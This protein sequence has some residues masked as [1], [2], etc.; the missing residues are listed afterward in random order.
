MT[1]IKQ[2][3]CQ[4]ADGAFTC[5]GCDTSCSTTYKIAHAVVSV[6]L[7]LY[8]YIFYII[9]LLLSIIIIL[10]TVQYC[11]VLEN[12]MSAWE[13]R[14]VRITSGKSASTF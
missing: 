4:A 14:V 3:C 13:E 8:I 5:A 11:G 7:K 1:G 10:W 6:S 2:C 12:V 9:L